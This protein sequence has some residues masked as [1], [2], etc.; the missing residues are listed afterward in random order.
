MMKDETPTIAGG[1]LLGGIASVG[2]AATG[3][4]LSAV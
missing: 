4:N 2:I 1:Y 3:R